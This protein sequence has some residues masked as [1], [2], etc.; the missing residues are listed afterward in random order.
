MRYSSQKHAIRTATAAIA[1]LAGAATASAQQTAQNVGLEE[2]TVTAQRYSENLQRT[3]LSVTALTADALAE[4]QVFNIRDLQAQIP[5]AIVSNVVGL[6][7]APRIFLRGVGQD[8]ATFNSD[9]AVGTYVDGIYIP[10]LYAG[11]F[12][13]VDV[14]RI[15]VLRGPQ[16]T[17]YGRNT[18]GGAIKLITKRPSLDSVA[19]S[20]EAGFGTF[21]QF[22]AKAYLTAPIVEDKLGASVSGLVRRRDGFV[23]QPALGKKVNNRDV[24]SVRGKFLFAPSDALEAELIVDHTTDDSGAFF[25]VAIQSTSPTLPL[26]NRFRWPTASAISW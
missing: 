26:A 23:S 7:T 19:G 20:V 24:T 6:Q 8:S 17:L 3:P 10:R 15:E 16:G 21:N 2:I 5:G 14:D 18:S 11:M 1:L 4:R 12:D 9:S 13:F 25:P 22:D